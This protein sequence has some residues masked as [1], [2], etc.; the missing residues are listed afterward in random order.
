QL[1]PLI[2]AS[3]MMMTGELPD[4]PA[5]NFMINAGDG[6]GRALA[7]RGLAGCAGEEGVRRGCSGL[8]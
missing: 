2:Q 1:T 7:G 4:S 8:L 3:I 5:I 6:R